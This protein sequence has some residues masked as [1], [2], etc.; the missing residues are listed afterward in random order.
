MIT[1]NSVDKR[2]NT[3][4]LVIFSDII[5]NMKCSTALIKAFEVIKEGLR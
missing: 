5:T 4:F 3:V 1:E 2:I